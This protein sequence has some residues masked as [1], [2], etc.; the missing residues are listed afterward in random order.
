[1]RRPARI[2]LLLTL[3]IP[4]W[5]A[6][7]GTLFHH[8]W[9]Y[10]TTSGA[11]GTPQLIWPKGAFVPHNVSRANLVV[12]VHPR[13]PCTRP[14]I[15][16][17]AEIMACARDK[18]AAHVLVYTPHSSEEGWEQTDIWHNAS[19]IPGVEVHRDVDGREAV[20]FGA[21]TSGHALLYDPAGHL[22]F[23][24]GLTNARG[25]AGKSAGRNAILALVDNSLPGHTRTPIFGCPL[26]GSSERC[27]RCQD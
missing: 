12:A 2:T 1:M 6:V 23:S 20:R 13:C 4:I 21:E 3:S 11:C 16:E 24:G 15:S 9:Q 8:I 26:F 7:T 27:T 5:L 19:A 10:E 25:H 17:L 22:I 18:V 14:T